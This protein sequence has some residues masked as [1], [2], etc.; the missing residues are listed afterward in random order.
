MS[1]ALSRLALSAASRDIVKFRCMSTYKV[2]GTLR[3]GTSSTTI[4]NEILAYEVERFSVMRPQPLSLREI[5]DMR[6]PSTVARFIHKEVPLRY[7]KRMREIELLPNWRH[8]SDLANLHAHHI[9]VFQS[10]RL[11]EHREPDNYSSLNSIEMH[12]LLPD[13][14]DVVRHAHKFGITI[15]WRITKVMRELHRNQS[16]RFPADWVDRWLDD[17]LLNWIGCETLLMHYIACSRGREN[18]IIEPYCDVAEVCQ[19]VSSTILDMC[20]DI[21]GLR[22]RIIVESFAPLFSYIPMFLRFIMQEILKNSCRATLETC[23]EP[24][25]PTAPIAVSVCADEHQLSIRVSD[26]GGGMPFHVGEKVWSYLYS[27]PCKAKP[28]NEEY[29]DGPTPLSGYGVGL[30]LSRLYCR[31]LGGLM[32]LVSWPGR[33]VDV[34]LSLPH[35]CIEQIEVVPD[36]DHHYKSRGSSLF[37]P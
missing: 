16:E 10:L 12:Q 33:G 30:P 22:P 25:L 2:S 15:P 9:D 14:D 4:D 27:T 35:M 3:S 11:L 19:S 6:E 31:Y 26:L 21:Y 7:A 32:H 36:R 24:Q 28:L 18:G 37:T 23:P 13:F 29:Q 5:W 34:H 8:D 17:F 20:E 1:V